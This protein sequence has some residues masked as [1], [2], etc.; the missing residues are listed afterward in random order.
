MTPAKKLICAGE[1]HQPH[2]ND[3]VL[4]LKASDKCN[5]IVLGL[6]FEE[7]LCSVRLIVPLKCLH[8]TCSRLSL[9]RSN[10]I[11]YSEYN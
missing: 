10:T 11:L 1:I 7:G 8:A 5:I 3:N 6:R 2:K 9:I 4:I